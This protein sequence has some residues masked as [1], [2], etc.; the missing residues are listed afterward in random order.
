MND[1]DSVVV[2]LEPRP[3]LPKPS[4]NSIMECVM[5]FEDLPIAVQHLV[6]NYDAELVSR[7]NNVT[8]RGTYVALTATRDTDLTILDWCDTNSIERYAADRRIIKSHITLVTAQHKDCDIPAI[9]FN[10]PLVVKKEETALHICTDGGPTLLQIR[11]NTTNP[12]INNLWHVYSNYLGVS[13]KRHLHVTLTNLKTVSSRN[14]ARKFIGANF[15]YD[16]H[17]DTQHVSAVQG[18]RME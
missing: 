15:P 11:I 9:K 12:I 5:K 17:F 6:A 4:M 10:L 14:N 3:H 7:K 16:L 1:L 13:T 8:G 2:A 18:C